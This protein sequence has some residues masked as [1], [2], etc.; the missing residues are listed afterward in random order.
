VRAEAKRLIVLTALLAGAAA[1]AWAWPAPLMES[2]ARDARRLL[3]RTLA[4]LMAQREREIHRA[5]QQFPPDLYRSMATDLSDGRLQPATVAVLEGRTT[6]VLELF[7][8]QRVSE[9]IVRLGALYRIPADL[10]DP[11]L[12]A[13]PEGYP[14][15]VTREYYAFI[16]ASL[17]KIPVVLDNE[18]A[19]RL[20]AVNLPGY[21]QSILA[22]SR[23]DAP[24][25]RLEL[26]QNG[27][28]I[29]H[30]TIDYRSPVF[31]VASLSYSRAVTAIAATWLSL[32]RE[33]RGDTT[34]M[35]QPIE[36]LPQDNAPLWTPIPSPPPE[37]RH[38]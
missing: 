37:G 8:Q 32:W 10:S 31:G 25:I 22:R 1:S 4:M 5:A 2:L 34:R 21:W 20:P 14:S 18:A 9:A 13:G 23:S 11:V 27:R 6:D 38:R 26:F 17:D 3:P 29:D 16:D 28:V 15:G 36:L 35:P 30:R 24:V 12:S 19:L 7:R 33:V